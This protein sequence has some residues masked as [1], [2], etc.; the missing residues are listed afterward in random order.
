MDKNNK[1]KIQF[2]FVLPF[3]LF[4]ISCNDT[5]EENKIPRVII[6][7]DIGGSDPDDYQSMVHLLVYADQFDIKGIIS[8]PPHEGRKEHIEEVLHAYAQDYEN[9]KTHSNSF[10]PPDSL[11][12]VTKQGA[13]QPQKNQIPE[14][15]SEGAEWIIKK[16]KEE[17]GKPLYILVW[18]SITDVAQAVHDDPGIKEH[19]RIYS[20]GSWNT[21]QDQN[22]RDYLY[23][24]HDDL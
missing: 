4:Q 1:I 3:L 16:A 19:I 21:L 14:E 12:H 11:L 7:T 18:G 10:P 6:S 8:S 9:L 15:L 2:F 13:I 17:R 24:N 20:I 22:A 5:K 23:K